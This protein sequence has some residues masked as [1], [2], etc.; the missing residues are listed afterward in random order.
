MQSAA[1]S[2]IRIAVVENDPL[3]F[4]GLRAMFEDEH[5]FALQ[6]CTPASIFKAR[7]YDVVLIGSRIGPAMY[8]IMA[9]L[10]AL[11]PT[12]CIIAT[13]NVPG[14]ETALRAL[15]AG[16]KGY[17]EESSPAKEFKQ[18]IRTV[19]GG[20]VWASRKLISKFIE[21]VTN[22]PRRPGR[23]EPLVFTERERDVLHLLVSG[24][25][26]KEIG[27]ALG[28]EER[29]VKMHVAKLMRKAGVAN[30]I[31]LSVHALTHSLLAVDQ[32]E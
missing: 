17:V 23:E 22:I 14:D 31:A 27:A 3:R 4:V 30:R 29:T 21:R 10:K 6:N 11:N 12:V 15:C 1:K 24:R 2:P 19:H 9:G 7:G 13:G 18:A 32:T 16:A 5:D 28:I 25:T 20:S 8:E 26:N